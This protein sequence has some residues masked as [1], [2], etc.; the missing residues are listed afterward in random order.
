MKIHPDIATFN[1]NFSQYNKYEESTKIVNISISK[2]WQQT[3]LTRQKAVI[4][5]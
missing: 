1:T 3:N 4:K 5:V 2:S